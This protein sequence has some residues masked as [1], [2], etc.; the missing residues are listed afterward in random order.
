MPSSKDHLLEFHKSLEAY[1]RT[2]RQAQLLNSYIDKNYSS[3]Y[4]AQDLGVDERYVRRVIAQL[5][6]LSAEDGITP[7]F[8]ASRFVDAGQ[9]IKGK[10]TLTKDDEGNIVWI[11][12]TAKAAAEDLAESVSDTV[13]S[14]TP[15]P[16]VAKP[17]TTEN[18]LCTLYTITDYH[19]GAYSWARETGDDWDI[20]IAQKVLINAVNDLINGSPK[21]SQAVLCQLGDF[22]H[23]DGLL[24]VTPT[25]KNVLD[26]DGRFEKL[27]EIATECCI[28]IVNLLLQSHDKVHVIMAEGN[29]DLA[30]SV[31]LRLLMK[32]VFGK[33][34]RVTVEDSPFPYYKFSW[35]NSFLG[36]HHGHLSRINKMPAK[37]YSEFARDMGQSAYRYL[38]TGHLHHK[39][40]V[41]DAGVVVER[42]PTLSA[43]DAHG[44]RGFSNSIRA[45]QSITYDKDYG[46]VSRT[47]VY[48]RIK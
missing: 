15:W 29:H 12:T 20:S 32:Q 25:A 33:N 2:N 22:L 28:N 16:K 7:S 44:S 5:K 6:R 8:D 40:V 39:E 3:K 24:A 11:K 19:I 18:K 45:A 27:T 13:A 48:P 23:W 30:A 35:G 31:W 42:H 4:A 41:E 14:L 17:K 21:S 37:F 38:H 36:F 34:K 26:A 9:K 10:S 47:V 46:E 43:R 1:C